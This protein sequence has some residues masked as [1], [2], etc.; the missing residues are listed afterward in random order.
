[1]L[2]TEPPDGSGA[3]GADTVQ[4][5]G[6]GAERETPSVRMAPG[7]PGT[8]WPELGAEQG[9]NTGNTYIYIYV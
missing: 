4:H 7:P 9:I 8:A 5:R 1:M 6:V 3:G 2:G